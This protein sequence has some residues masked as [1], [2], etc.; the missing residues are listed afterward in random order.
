MVRSAL[1]IALYLLIG[2]FTGRILGPLFIPDPTGMLAAALTISVTVVVSMF[3]YRSDWL[4]EQ[5]PA[6]Q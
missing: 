4:R 5:K 2:I 3:L 1:R 6:A